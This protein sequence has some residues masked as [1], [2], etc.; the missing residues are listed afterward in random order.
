MVFHKYREDIRGP[1]DDFSL[2]VAA[3]PT[4][5]P[6]PH[7]TTSSKAV[8]LLDGLPV[9]AAAN[10]CFKV[11]VDGEMRTLPAAAKPKIVMFVDEQQR[12]A[13][14]KP[15][16]QIIVK[17]LTGNVFTL[18]VAPSDTIEDVKADIQHREG[19]PP[20]Q[21]L[22]MFGGR[23]VGELVGPENE[24]SLA[25]YGI[26]DNDML[27]LVQFMQIFVK[28]LDGMTITVQACRHETV[29]DLKAKIKEREGIPTDQQ[30]LIFAGRQ[31][32]DGR[33]FDYYNIQEESTVHLMLR[34]RGGMFHETSGRHG[35]NASS[36]MESGQ[37][38]QQEG[39]DTHQQQPASNG[40]AGGADDEEDGNDQ[41]QMSS[42]KKKRP[43]AKPLF[44]RSAIA[45][46]LVRPRKTAKDDK[47]ERVNNNRKP[48]NGTAGTVACGGGMTRKM[49]CKRA[50]EQTGTAADR[51][52][53]KRTKKEK[54]LL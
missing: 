49:A 33:T 47:A 48:G 45:A 27:R 43:P 29:T 13:Q 8:G 25:S 35:F 20:F 30:R 6:T 51:R 40:G 11:R 10:G 54:G 52:A 5:L 12:P 23:T 9:Y 32:E 17:A 46:G 15:T 7:D 50:A 4:P 44:T 22:L 36:A 53:S 42:E 31:L 21:Q 16:M 2:T 39:P 41:H 24:R 3:P 14:H 34:L 38:D 28:R 19:T 1:G 18:C 26:Q 37:D